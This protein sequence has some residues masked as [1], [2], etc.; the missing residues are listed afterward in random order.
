ME[1]RIAKNIGYYLY[2]CR[3]I[4][5]FTSFFLF[6]F[7]SLILISLS[8]K[9]HGLWLV[10][11]LLVISVW[12]FFQTRAINRSYSFLLS[13][14]DT[15]DRKKDED[16]FFVLKNMKTCSYWQV[17]A[18]Y[19]FILFPFGLS[20]TFYFGFLYHKLRA[21]YN[22]D[23]SSGK[24]GFDIENSLFKDYENSGRLVKD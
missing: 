24:E 17:V 3:R 6:G 19:T 10:P 12:I 4:L 16:L 8:L 23:V 21:I 1:D 7:P 20:A 11:F 9:S 15:V 18:F 14:I 5:V 13:F 2:L 22:R